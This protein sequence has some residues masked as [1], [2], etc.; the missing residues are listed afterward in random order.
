MKQN[1]NIGQRASA[2]VEAAQ[3]GRISIDEAE[4]RLQ[5]LAMTA[6]RVSELE[7][8]DDARRILR[9][10]RVAGEDRSHR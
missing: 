2:I 10:L 1:A 4:Q 3:K 9:R 7:E 6:Q 8:V 5:D